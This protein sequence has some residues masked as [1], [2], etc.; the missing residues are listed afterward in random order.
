MAHGHL[1]APPR[2]RAWRLARTATGPLLI[3][4]LAS[5]TGSKRRPPALKRRGYAPR[6]PGGSALG[7][8]IIAGQR[9]SRLSCRFPSSAGR[10]AGHRSLISCVT[11]PAPPGFRGIRPARSRRRPSR[12][13]VCYRRAAAGITVEPVPQRPGRLDIVAVV[14]EEPLPG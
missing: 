7:Q 2:G 9:P 14:G 10:P 11:K 5:L 8:A 6:G 12:P 3:R 4:P 13:E 1:L